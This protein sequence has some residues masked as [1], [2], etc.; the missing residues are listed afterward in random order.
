M[1]LTKSIRVLLA[2]AVAAMA[3][4]A[5]FASAATAEEWQAKFSSPSIKLST[6]GITLKANGGEP[7]TCTAVSLSGTAQENGAFY[8]GNQG[9]KA[10][11]K[12]SCGGLSIFTMVFLGE[13][14]YED[15]TGQYMVRVSNFGGGW[16][17]E[18]PWG[19]YTQTNDTEATW[20]NGS[21]ATAST[22]TFNNQTVGF[23]TSGKAVSISG[24][25]KATTPTGGLLTL[26]H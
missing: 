13:A 22:V 8:V 18:S 7:K 26:S 4:S 24:T 5:V 9:G 15:E 11:S 16:S 20:V 21:G 10:E 17:L 1:H 25:F 3:L 23:T 2:T 14:F 6:T 12:F 19:S